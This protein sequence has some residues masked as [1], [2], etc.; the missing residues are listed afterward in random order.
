MAQQDSSDRVQQGLKREYSEDKSKCLVTFWL[1][2]EAAPEARCIALA[3]TFNNWDEKSHLLSKLES[4]DFAL[5][6]ELEAGK[7]HEFRFL[8]D[9][10]RWEN[11]WNADK[12]VGS[13][14]GDCENSVVIT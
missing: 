14:Y 2:K 7:E 13:P 9:E 6:V 12:Y 11:A 5:T 4:G 3:G 1:A 10:T 8:I